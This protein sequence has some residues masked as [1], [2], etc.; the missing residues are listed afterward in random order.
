MATISFNLAPSHGTRRLGLD[1]IHQT[2]EE[3]R[4]PTFIERSFRGVGEALPSTGR[5]SSAFRAARRSKAL[6]IRSPF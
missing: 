1:A 3:S 6:T 2:A 5:M 4:L